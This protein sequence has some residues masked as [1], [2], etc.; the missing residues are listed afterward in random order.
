MRTTT[1]TECRAFQVLSANRLG[2]HV[3]CISFVHDCEL[4][5]EGKGH[6]PRGVSA[7]VMEGWGLV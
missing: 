2:K 1:R 6:L 3:T 4:I 7:V 5:I